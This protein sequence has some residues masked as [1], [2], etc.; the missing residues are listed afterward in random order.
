MVDGL[1]RRR[2]KPCFWWAWNI[3]FP[4]LPAPCNCCGRFAWWGFSTE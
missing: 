2:G 4:S 1:Y 3:T